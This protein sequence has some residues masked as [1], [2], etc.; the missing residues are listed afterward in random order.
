MVEKG[1]KI[2]VP[3]PY[4]TFDPNGAHTCAILTELS[5][6]KHPEW[7]YG[8]TMCVWYHGVAYDIGDWREE[9]IPKLCP[10]GHTFEEI[11]A[12]IQLLLER[13]DWGNRPVDRKSQNGGSSAKESHA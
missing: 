6:M 1:Q 10:R 2:G 8:G 4:M 5:R 11:D 13:V 3:C 7:N 12:K 9:D